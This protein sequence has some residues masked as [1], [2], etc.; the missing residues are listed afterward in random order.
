VLRTS[1]EQEDAL[2]RISRRA[3]D[4]WLVISGDIDSWNVE[5][6]REALTAANREAG[7]VDHRLHNVFKVIGWAG[8]P[9]LSIDGH[10]VYAT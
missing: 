7:D 6:I 4:E 5:A 10:E 2:L 3:Q 1:I 9:S 8:M